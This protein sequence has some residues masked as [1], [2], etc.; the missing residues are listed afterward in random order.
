[1]QTEPLK[2]EPPKRKRHWY[3]FS[4]L[5]VMLLVTLACVVASWIAWRDYK[6]ML[7]ISDHIFGLTSASVGTLDASEVIRGTPLRGG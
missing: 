3:Q 2:P 1:M 4:L 7:G 5:A 6:A